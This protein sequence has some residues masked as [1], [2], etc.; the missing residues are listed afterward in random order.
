MFL[1]YGERV[2]QAKSFEDL[3]H[4][5]FSINWKITVLVSLDGRQKEFC[6][7]DKKLP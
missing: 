3:K 5:R 1:K 2:K 4:F 6:T 7:K